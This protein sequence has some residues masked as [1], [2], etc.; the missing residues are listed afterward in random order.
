MRA[1]LTF[2]QQQ[3]GSISAGDQATWEPLATAD[4]ISPNNAYT[5]H[6]LA[7]WRTLRAPSK[8]FPSTETG[9]AGYDLVISATGGVRN[10]H[11]AVSL[12]SEVLQNWGFF[13]HHS[14]IATP[15]HAF[16][17]LIHIFH[18]EDLLTHNWT[19][20]P[21][22]AGTHYYRIQAFTTTGKTETLATVTDSAVVT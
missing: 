20:A 3:W 2:L 11:L 4:Q 16:D 14:T 19:H 1:M 17:N 15:N 12:D 18:V 21:L 22:T 10:V 7:R 9:T 5:R 8:A 13:L 6:N